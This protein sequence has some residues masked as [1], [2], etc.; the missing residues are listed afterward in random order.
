MK[1]GIDRNF[2]HYGIR[3]QDLSIISS[4]S[5]KYGL[6][7]EWIKEDLLKTFHEARVNDVDLEDKDIIKILNKALQKIR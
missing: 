4:L 7:D 1:K 2:L 5:E 6:D 3:T